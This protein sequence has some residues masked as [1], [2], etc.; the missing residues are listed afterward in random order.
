MVLDVVTIPTLSASG[1][2]S[3]QGEEFGTADA[4]RHI[5]DKLKA[6][7]VMVVSSDLVTDVQVNTLLIWDFMR[8]RKFCSI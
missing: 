4:I 3:S 7:R 1:S 5:H 8:R 2:I 6:N